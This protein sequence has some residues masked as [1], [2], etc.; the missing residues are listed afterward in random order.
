MSS[1]FLSLCF[2]LCSY[3]IFFSMLFRFI[4]IL[5][6]LLYCHLLF[7]LY[8]HPVSQR[9]AVT[10]TSWHDRHEVEDPP[11]Y[12]HLYCHP[13]HS[14]ILSSCSFFS[15]VILSPSAALRVNSAKDPMLRSREAANLYPQAATTNSSQRGILRLRLR[16]TIK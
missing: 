12:S 2:L 13:A 9:R 15:T 1:L 4:V 5:T 6:F 10:N 16:M 7:F 14:S 3:A 11:M 8:C